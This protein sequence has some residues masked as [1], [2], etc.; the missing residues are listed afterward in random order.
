M[1]IIRDATQADLLELTRIYNEQGVAGT[2]SYD[3]EP[4]S[5]EARQQWFDQHTIIVAERSGTI[6]GYACWGPFHPK[7][8]Y[9]TTAEVSVYLDASAQGQGLGKELLVELISRARRSGL[10]ALVG[11]IDA[12]NAASRKLVA[13]LGF[14]EQGHLREVGRKFGRWL[15]VV[16]AVLIL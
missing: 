2:A 8:G 13:S 15:D 10:H 5:V 4:V 11:L 14:V 12:D 6:E 9:A 7:P 1:R 3:L 16:Y